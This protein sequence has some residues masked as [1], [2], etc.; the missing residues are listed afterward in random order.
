[1]KSIQQNQTAEWS[2]KSSKPRKDPFNAVELSARFTHADGAEKIVPA[3]WAGGNEWR[4]RFASSQTGNYRFQTV[5]SDPSDSG[6]HDR[7]GEFQ[8]K[9][10]TGS[11]PLFLHGPIRVAADKRHFEHAD[12]APFFWLGDTWWM[13]LT[14]RLSWPKGFRTLTRDRVKKGFTVI[15]IVAGLYPDMPAFDPRGANEAGFPWDK[16]Y[17]RINPAYFNLAD[18]RIRYLAEAGLAPCIV[19][20]WGYFLPWMGVERMK[21]HWRNLVAR[22]GSYPVI[23]C[24]A[25]EGV[26][27]YY[28]S[29][30]KEQDRQFQ[31]KGWREIGAYLRAMD[32]YHRIVTIHPC[33]SSRKDLGSDRKH[34]IETSTRV[35]TSITDGWRLKT[36][37][38]NCGEAQSWQRA[39]IDRTWKP[40]AITA[41]WTE[42]GY[43]YHGAAWYDVECAFPPDI[44]NS[45]HLYFHAVDGTAKVWI[46]GEFAGE[47]ARPAD[48][49][50]TRPWSLEIGHLIASKK[51]ARITVKVVKERLACGIYRPVELRED[52]ARQNPRLDSTP[53]APKTE[54]C[55][56]FVTDA[57]DDAPSV[58]DFDMLQTGH[59]DRA[60]LPNTVKCVSEGYQTAPAMPV[61]EGEVNYEGIGEQ[62]RQEVQRLM[63]WACILNGAAGY[64]YGANGIWQVNTRKRPYGPSPHGMTWGNTPWEDAYRLPGSGQLGLAKRFLSRYPWWNFEPHPEWVDPCW[65][66]ELNAMQFTCGRHE[67]SMAA[68][69]PGKVR[70]IYRPVGGCLRVVKNLEKGVRY[71]FGLFNPVDGAE[72]EIGDVQPDAS[73]NWNPSC[74]GCPSW[75]PVPIYQDWVFVLEAKGARI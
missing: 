20:C 40:I 24:L 57:A 19:A 72:M 65:T 45:A 49:M 11:N 66:E 39:E 14:K 58:L 27:P 59:G 25:G 38:G 69:I 70:I 32:P 21:K 68:G 5:C 35:L 16:D 64:T 33:A 13:G 17:E 23:W 55:Y 60:S 47:Q 1:M 46:D 51:K 34:R 71:K 41:P 52:I 74:P 2:F 3:F 42:Q 6:L 56:E 18:R 73:G 43:E 67:V 75:Q 29:S 12:G 28:L 63:F 9:R 10:Y 44:K 31:K 22:Y 62:C 54:P 48:I 30:A 53:T 15:Q 37:P 36:D 4:V 8:V 7:A 50:W 26:M 61:V